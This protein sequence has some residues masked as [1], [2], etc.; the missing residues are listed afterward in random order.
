M[1]WYSTC[2][3]IRD[4]KVTPSYQYWLRSFMR[5]VCA[6][7]HTHH[8][9][10]ISHQEITCQVTEGYLPPFCSSAHLNTFFRVQALPVCPIQASCDAASKEENKEKN[11][12]VNI[13][14]CEQKLH[15]DTVT[16]T[17]IN[18]AA[19]KTSIRIILINITHLTFKDGLQSD[20]LRDIIGM[21]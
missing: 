2:L 6:A 11:R 18:K 14:P 17:C 12:Y 3:I 16:Q 1:Y 5:H 19:L 21:K 13:L 4:Q 15:P 20:L 8:T 9:K 7:L 10:R